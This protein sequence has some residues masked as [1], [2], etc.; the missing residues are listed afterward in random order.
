MIGR[1]YTAG[2]LLQC[3]LFSSLAIFGQQ[4]AQ[5]AASQPTAQA[6]APAQTTAKDANHSMPLVY[7]GFSSFRTRLN[8]KRV[9]IIRIRT[10][11]SAFKVMT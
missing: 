5:N 4:S 9:L 1:R 11:L 7:L 6:S 8:T 2:I 3:F 10:F